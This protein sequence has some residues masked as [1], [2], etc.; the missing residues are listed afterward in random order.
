MSRR[1]SV[2]SGG[3]AAPPRALR[4]VL[5]AGWRARQAASVGALDEA[6][7]SMLAS[8]EDGPREL[9]R[10]LL[11]SPADVA[12]ARTLLGG[13]PVPEGDAAPVPEAGAGA[14]ASGS[15]SGKRERPEEEGPYP[16]TDLLSRPRHGAAQDLASRWFRI[17]AV[18]DGRLA[19]RPGGYVPEGEGK[20]F[21]ILREFF[22]FKP[23]ETDSLR[24]VVEK[25]LGKQDSVWE[26]HACDGFHWGDITLHWH[27]RS[28]HALGSLSA[29]D[30]KTVKKWSDEQWADNLEQWWVLR[31][32]YNRA[33]PGSAPRQ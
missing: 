11:E 26:K 30:A 8:L 24:R 23:L 29:P 1:A 17:K 27:S 15:G 6:Q 7:K 22:G 20:P 21:R 18:L 9:L 10:R 25:V 19:D 14:G 33:D 16:G 28:G 3:A 13:A 4:D 31:Q 12:H 32:M 2:S 5:A